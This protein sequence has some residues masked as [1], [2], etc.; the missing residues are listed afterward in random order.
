[1]IVIVAVAKTVKNGDKAQ[2][3]VVKKFLEETTNLSWTNKLF[4]K[5]RKSSS[6]SLRQENWKRSLIL[7]M[8]QLRRH[9]LLC[10]RGQIRDIISNK[11]RKLAKWMRLREWLLKRKQRKMS[12]INSKVSKAKDKSF[13]VKVEEARCG[14]QTKEIHKVSNLEAKVIKVKDLVELKA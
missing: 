10:N 2:V 8:I 7:V 13:K 3:R 12:T 14:V 1:M 11:M 4:Q 9:Q 6:I 5:K